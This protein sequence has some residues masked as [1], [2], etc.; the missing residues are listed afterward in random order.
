MEWRLSDVEAH[1][2]LSLEP[3]APVEVSD[4]T[5]FI[6]F[7]VRSAIDDSEEIR[8]AIELDSYEFH[9]R[10]VEQA[11]RDKKRERRIVESGIPVLRFTGSE[12]L[13]DAQSCIAKI[14]RFVELRRKDRPEG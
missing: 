2:R 14:V 6:D 10:S 3:Q 7:L 13:R 11:T 4:G 1:H 5:F 8:V 12:I 9:E